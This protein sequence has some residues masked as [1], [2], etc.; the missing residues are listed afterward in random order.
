LKNI[1][2]RFRRRLAGVLKTSTIQSMR[3]HKVKEKS[4]ADGVCGNLTMLEESKSTTWGR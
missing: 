1:I 2:Q 4:N 3:K